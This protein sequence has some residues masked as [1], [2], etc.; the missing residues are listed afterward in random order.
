MSFHTYSI[1]LEVCF[2]ESKL[3]FDRQLF[4]GIEDSKGTHEVVCAKEKQV[5]G[6]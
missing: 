6:R 3:H 1:P 4:D 2:I 5:E